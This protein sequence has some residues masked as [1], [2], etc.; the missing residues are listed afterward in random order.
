MAVQAWITELE[1]SDGSTINLTES[2][3]VVIVGANN[4]GK[5]AF[6]RDSWAL[7]IDANNR[8][9][10]TVVKRIAI[11]TEGSV[12]ELRQ[13]AE[14]SS[15]RRLNQTIRFPITTRSERVYIPKI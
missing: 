11:A 12:D 2:D 15:R 10:A 7:V 5:S 13:F 1:C 14:E 3:T 8:N 4:A 9:Q 6:L